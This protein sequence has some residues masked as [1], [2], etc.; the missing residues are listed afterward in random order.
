MK[1]NGQPKLVWGKEHQK[2]EKFVNV[3]KKHVSMSI[4]FTLLAINV[5]E[6]VDSVLPEQV[7]R[8]NSLTWARS[9]PV[10][11]RTCADPLLHN[12]RETMLPMDVTCTSLDIVRGEGVGKMMEDVDRMVCNKETNII[13][14]MVSEEEGEKGEE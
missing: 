1:K 14:S 2:M 13:V 8:F 11:C 10:L 6:D 3:L 7:V 4:E 9:L 12:K 5:V